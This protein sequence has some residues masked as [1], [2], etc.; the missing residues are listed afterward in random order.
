MVNHLVSQNKR[1][2]H[3]KITA[4]QIAHFELHGKVVAADRSAGQK[5]P[6]TT[7]SLIEYGS[8][9]PSSALSKAS[10]E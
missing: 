4:C 2:N 6:V 3:P 8:Q 1:N 5:F 10:H 7:A 9:R